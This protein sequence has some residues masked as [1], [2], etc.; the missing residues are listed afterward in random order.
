[1]GTAT[2]S[3]TARRDGG[4]RVAI[5]AGVQ[6]RKSKSRQQARRG[7]D[8]A[9]AGGA[10]AGEPIELRLEDV[11]EDPQQPRQTFAEEPMRELA[12]SIAA[13]GVKVPILVHR[14]P[15]IEGRYIVNDGARR[16]RASIR[17]GKD[18]VLAVVTDALSL[19]E[20]IVVNKVRDDTPPHDKAQAFLRLM[21]THGWSQAE[22][23]RR[24]KLSE[25]YVF[26]HL[27]L[28][29]MPPA[30]AAVFDSGR[31]TD[32][33][34]INELI[35]AYKKSPGEVQAWLADQDQEITRGSVRFLRA[36]LSNKSAVRPDSPRADAHHDPDFEDGAATAD[37][38]SD[39]DP[40]PLVG[41]TREFTPRSPEKVGR[42]VVLGTYERRSVRLITN[43]R[44]SAEG[45]AWVRFEDNGEETE[46]ALDRLK[47]KRLVEV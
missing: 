15:S 45:L 37:P 8:P 14:H 24:L 32:V 3:K 38:A 30:V 9:P 12:D 19:V 17:A 46:I 22:L 25:A 5:A 26:Q 23:A 36:F 7:S 47:L 4:K 43:R 27:G 21:R 18:T 35:K 13:H 41:A 29:H 28:L 42:I 44:W 16:V 34:L 1:M 33:T 31:C 6:P 20:Q 10:V 2:A 39:S 11:E 40:Q